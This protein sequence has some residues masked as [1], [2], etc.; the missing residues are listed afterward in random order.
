[1]TFRLK[2]VWIN[3]VLLI[4]LIVVAGLAIGLIPSDWLRNLRLPKSD[5]AKE[6]SN[7]NQAPAEFGTVAKVIDGITIQ[8]DS[9]HVVR[10]LGVRTPNIA[11]TIECFG[12]EA[13]KANESIIGKKVRLEEDPILPRSSDGAWVRYVYL[14]AEP[15]PVPSPTA[16]PENSPTITPAASTS[17][18]VSPTATPEPTP[19]GP[20][21]I[22]INERILEGG[23]G[24][25]VVSQDM[26]Y[27]ERMLSAARFA[28]ATGKGLWS[29]CEVSNDNNNLRTQAVKDCTIKGKVGSDFSKLYRTADC[30]AYKQ[31]IVVESQ[32]GR[33]FCAEDLA[34]DAGFTKAPDCSAE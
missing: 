34:Q 32:G 17:P 16:T 18:A 14:P 9:G 30:P 5:T 33:Y 10:Y 28:S 19:E 13:V 24:F 8:L 27:G 20:K 12:P 29:R 31:T 21:E 26:K 15:T 6:V 4:I 2:T 22:F 3:A 25:P 1:M 7:P 11:D 23:F